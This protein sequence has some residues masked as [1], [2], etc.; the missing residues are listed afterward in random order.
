MRGVRLPILIL[1]VLFAAAVALKLCLFVVDEMQY[2]VVTQFGEVKRTISQAGLY[3]RTPLVQEVHYLPKRI[4]RWKGAGKELVTKDKTYIWAN[5]WARWRIV[6]P[7]RFYQALRTEENGHGTLDDQIESATKDIIASQDLIE[8]VRNT[9]RELAYTLPELK[10]AVGVQ[11]PIRLGRKEMCRRILEVASRV[12]TESP[13]G[14]RE[15]GTLQ[16]VYGIELIDVQIS[17]VI[18]VREV[19][20]AV[21]DR[22]R[23]ERRRIAQRYRSEGQERA[24]QILGEMRKQ[25]MTILSEGHRRASE[26]RGEGDAEALSIYAAAYSKDPEFYRFWET[27]RTYEQAV[28]ERTILVLSLDNEYFRILGKPRLD[29]EAP[30]GVSLEPEAAPAEATGPAE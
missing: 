15:E 14:V 17:H 25:L 24:N 2:A 13:S 23:A 7:Q 28:D 18:Y 20:K 21:Y 16:S 12:V 9:N 8:L 1:V 26:L 6:D 19:Q 30:G 4:L 11:K 10:E 3:L 29:M 27:L 22:M 5:T